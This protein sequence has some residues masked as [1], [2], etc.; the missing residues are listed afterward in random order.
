MLK[1]FRID[2]KHLEYLQNLKERAEAKSINDTLN[3]LFFILERDEEF[4]DKMA[5]TYP[6]LR[7]KNQKLT[8]E[9]TRE[10]KGF[11]TDDEFKVL[12]RLSKENGFSSVNKFVRF[13][14]LSHLY[15]DKILS[16]D[17][18]NEFAQTNNSIK[19]VGINLNTFLKSIQQNSS[20]Y[21]DKGAINELVSQIKKQV[22]ETEA[23]VKEQKKFLLTK[24][25]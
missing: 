23:F 20:V 10:V 4:A 2:E 16:N 1:S 9:N 13:L 19:R 18:I 6:L 11:Y 8:K 7:V 22:E 3:L 24:L 14:V 12:Q 21:F 5:Q 17:T 25:R 15:D